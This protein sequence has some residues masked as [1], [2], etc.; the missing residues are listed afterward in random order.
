MVLNGRSLLVSVIIVTHN[1]KDKLS[2]LLNSV[3]KS[4]Y[5]PIEVIVVDDCSSDGT[6]VM[7]K[8]EFPAVTFIRNNQELELAASRNLGV[9]LSHGSY[10]F[11]IDDDNIIESKT[12]KNMVRTLD[13]RSS[14]AVLGPIA[15]YA[16]N[17]EIIW[18]AG[19]KRGRFSQFSKFLGH[20]QAKGAWENNSLIECDDFS[21]AF[22]VRQDAFRAIGGFDACCF[23]SHLGEA[24]FCRRIK[25]CGFGKVVLDPQAIVWH[26][27]P[28]M[29]ANQAFS[30]YLPRVSVAYEWERNRVILQRKYGS[31][32]DYVSFMV[33]FEPVYIGIF[34]I[35]ML[36]ISCSFSKKA[37]VIS[38]MFRGVRDALVFGDRFCERIT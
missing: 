35:L 36:S 16:C 34:L 20:N 11:I 37:K 10:L 22:M 19:T 31:L 18:G 24:D 23:P 30:R 12:I 13:L 25:L 9:K 4:E 14:I 7:I 17:P 21:N 32:M 26:D 6:D 33:L 2:C 38:R 5:Q 27:I 1:R 28:I 8:R 3:F 15:Y 29:A